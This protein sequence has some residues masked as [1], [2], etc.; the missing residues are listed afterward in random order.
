MYTVTYK[1]IEGINETN[2][3]KNFLNTEEDRQNLLEIAD[4]IGVMIPRLPE[5]NDPNYIELQT[6]VKRALS[7]SWVA[8]ETPKSKL[9]SF[10]SVSMKKMTYDT[11]DVNEF[12]ELYS[13]SNM[14]INKLMP[15][16]TCEIV[17]DAEVINQLI[18]SPLAMY[19]SIT[20]PDGKE[21]YNGG[22]TE[23]EHTLETFNRKGEPVDKIVTLKRVCNTLHPDKL[24]QLYQKQE[25]RG[26]KPKEEKEG[27]AK[28]LETVE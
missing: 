18:Q 9:P 16:E 20:N 27:V 21:V 26:R 3:K 12:N 11:T 17:D 10:G 1:P 2:F 5:N 7:L 22:E 8:S 28:I 25:T 14:G 23:Y 4:K 6:L 15:G 19:I 13:Q 24:N